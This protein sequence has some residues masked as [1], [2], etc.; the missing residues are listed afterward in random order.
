[1]ISLLVILLKVVP[2]QKSNSE[3]ILI[4]AY[5][6]SRRTI[7]YFISP[8]R[9]NNNVVVFPIPFHIFMP[10]ANLWLIRLQRQF[11]ILRTRCPDIYPL[12]HPPKRPLALGRGRILILGFVQ[13]PPTLFVYDVA[14]SLL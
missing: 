12:I 6:T 1:L 13:S 8:F 7:I 10:L 3:S 14:H 5:F 2:T 4:P 9:K 11:P